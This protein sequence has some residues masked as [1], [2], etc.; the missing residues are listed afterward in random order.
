MHFFLTS[1]V[2]L[3]QPNATISCSLKMYC[4]CCYA[5]LCLGALTVLLDWWKGDMHMA[6]GMRPDPLTSVLAPWLPSLSLLSLWRQTLYI[7][8]FLADTQM[9][10]FGYWREWQWMMEWVRGSDGCF[11]CFHISSWENTGKNQEKKMIRSGVRNWVK[12][13]RGVKRLRKEGYLEMQTCTPSQ[14]EVS[15]QEKGGREG[16]RAPGHGCRQTGRVTRGKR[17][18]SLLLEDRRLY[19]KAWS[20]LGAAEVSASQPGDSSHL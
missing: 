9:D 4:V 14:E 12:V 10:W 13:R 7:I 6:R 5:L 11:L 17:W 15:R 20:M 2:S 3:W 1:H 19:L 8:F 18:P 16:G